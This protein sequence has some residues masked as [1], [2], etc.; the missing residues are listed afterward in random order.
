MLVRVWT[1][2][3]TQSLSESASEMS[4]HKTLSPSD[5]STGTVPV[6][7]PPVGPGPKGTTVEAGADESIFSS[8]CNL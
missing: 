2:N 8:S 6:V 1:V 4:T 5:K 3:L 7:V